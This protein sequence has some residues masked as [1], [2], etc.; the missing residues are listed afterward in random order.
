[1]DVRRVTRT[2]LAFDLPRPMTV[3][4]EAVADADRAWF[5]AHRGHRWRVR[6]AAVIEWRELQ[7]AF[8]AAGW[9]PPVIDDDEPG[10]TVVIR[11]PHDVGVRVRVPVPPCLGPVETLPP[12]LLALATSSTRAEWYATLERIVRNQQHGQC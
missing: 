2:P 4:L 1:M 8:V 12:T 5:E 9:V 6:P 3:A 11:S 10:C 7:L